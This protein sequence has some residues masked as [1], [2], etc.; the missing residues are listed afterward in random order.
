GGHRGGL[1]LHGGAG[2]RAVAPEEPVLITE[3]RG[4][5]GDDGPRRERRLESAP[6]PR[7]S[8]PTRIREGRSVSSSTTCRPSNTRFDPPRHPDPCGRT[9][10]R[11]RGRSD[12]RSPGISPAP[13]RRTWTRSH[14]Y[15]N[16]RKSRTWM[17]EGRG[18]AA[19][20]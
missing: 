19:A 17:A 13:T 15:P 7:P 20:R 18:P 3:P 9:G 16:L 6:L 10:S 8:G 1:R 4:V 14:R 12:V 5:V 2:R 11:T